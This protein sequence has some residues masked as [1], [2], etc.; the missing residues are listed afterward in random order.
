[1]DNNRQ[2][3]NTP[4]NLLD[5]LA[6]QNGLAIVIVDESAPVSISNNN[7]ICEMLFSSEEF[8]SKCRMF[9][10]K[11][12]EQAKDAKEPIS[13]KC[14]AGINYQTFP[15]STVDNKPLAAIIG[16]AFQS[17]GEYRNATKRALEGDWRNF[18]P[19][20]L[21]EN[22]LLTNSDY[23]ISKLAKRLL[24][25]TD[26]ERALIFAEYQKNTKS[27]ETGETKVEN[28]VA[29]ISRLIEDFK[30][31]GSETKSEVEKKKIE[32]EE[33][34]SSVPLHNIKYKAE[35][36]AWRSLFSSLLDKEYLECL[37]AI[38]EF[39][40]SRYQIESVAWL[41][42]RRNLLEST[43]ATG[44][45]RGQQ[46]QLSIS[47]ND[48]RFLDVVHAETSLKL[49][50]QRKSEEKTE[51]FIHLFPVAIGG[52]IKNA[53]VI[54]DD[55]QS[56]DL[57]QR[58]SRFL[59]HIASDLEILRLREKVKQQSEVTKAV[60]KFNQAL[61][62]MDSEDFWLVLAQK[63]AELMRAE[64]SSILIY[65]ENSEQF[66]VKAAVGNRA[67]II[68]TLDN[69]RIGKRISQNV[70]RSGRPLV[71]KNAA[72]SG[73]ALSPREWDYKTDSFI[74]YPIII[75]GKKIGVL[76]ITDKV[77]GGS[78]DESD[79]E[80]LNTLAPQIALALDRTSLIRKAGEF[81][82]LSIT[83]PL[84]GLVNRRYLQERI[85]EE[86]NR[87]QRH[88]YPVSFLMIDVDSFKSYN[89]NFGH[90]EGDK[91]LQIVGQCLRSA[92]RGADIAARYGGEEFAIL[93]PQTT[94]KEAQI[95]A[96]RIRRKVE[97]TQF[98]NRQVTVSIGLSTA[99]TETKTADEFIETADKALYLAKEKG[100]NR[101]EVYQ[102]TEK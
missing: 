21:F 83:D 87:S 82:Q 68:K 64:R 90:P 17:A 65:D 85:T 35:I 26:E 1:M 92:L 4:V 22:I 50:E 58:I 71:I 81:Q 86:L 42:N 70:F 11:A 23:E 74:S 55:I 20:K 18:P 93:L 67:K 47:A 66:I 51:T 69:Q 96:E 84:T 95:I 76:N 28:E 30:S 13:V 75:G 43:W 25:L 36:S 2:T 94:F 32:E 102:K 29:E 100:R 52:K 97:K 15:L 91:A 6:E 33:T 44:K 80:L 57:K 7:S 101:I 78:Y 40:K 73:F 56:E 59:K 45:L 60:Q 49:R 34:K 39:L 37:A 19:S 24:K 98:P 16:R 14:H 54:G 62:Q 8:S 3:N 72:K 31:G 61:N 9:C 12:F 48:P 89:D 99:T 79:L 38:A 63:S 46:I 77:G 27:E 53:L 41:E 88:G 10:G 5:E